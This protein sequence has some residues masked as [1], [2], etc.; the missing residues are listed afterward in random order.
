MQ[1]VLEAVLA[2]RFAPWVQSLAL[3]VVQ[4]D[5]GVLTL[6][7]P[8][9]NALSRDG[10]T[11]CGQAMMAATDTAVVLALVAHFGE[12]RPCTTV[13]QST[14]FVRPLSAQDALVTVRLTRVGNS[15]AFAEVDI[16]GASDGKT[17]ARASTV[18]ALLTPK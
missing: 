10:G 11:L 7:L 6:R 2:E 18:Y 14:S 13:Q 9:N 1:R 15:M 17:A 4:V 12:F 3:R 16:V 5:D 8:Q